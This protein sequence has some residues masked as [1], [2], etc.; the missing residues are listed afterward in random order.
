MLENIKIT[1][2]L[3]TLRL[4][5]ISDDIYFSKKFGGYISNSRLSLI[6]PEQGGSPEKFISG[7]GQNAIYSDSLVFGS[8]VHELILQPESFQLVTSVDRPTAKAGFM[9]DELYKKNGRQPSY[10]EMEAASKKIDYYAKSWNKDKAEALLS[11]CNNYWRNRALF[12]SKNEDSKV[13]I[14]LDPKSRERLQGVLSNFSKNKEFI[15]LLNPE[16]LLNPIITKNEQTILLDVNVEVPDHDPFILRLKSKLDNYTI[17]SDTGEIVVNDV[18]TTGRNINDFKF[19]FNKYRY[20]REL[21]MYSWLLGLCAKKFYN[22]DKPTISSNCLVVETFGAYNTLTYKL[23][24]KDFVKGLA[25][26]KTLLRLVAHYKA[27]NNGR[28][29]WDNL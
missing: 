9:A 24:K 28:E 5:N 27:K 20:Y 17:D 1:P 19:A 22:I 3:D 13:P 23:T 2:N 16:G 7:L 26:F 29:E 21:G 4:E 15:S 14:Y 25:E 12:E 10:E 6:N 8:A 11:K 18:K